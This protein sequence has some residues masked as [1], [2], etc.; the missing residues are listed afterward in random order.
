MDSLERYDL[1]T[2]VVTTV[3]DGPIRDET[4][5]RD[6]GIQDSL[7]SAIAETLDGSFPGVADAG[8]GQES[9]YASTR[10]STS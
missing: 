6:P 5:P 8:R 10:G 3:F 9:G 7:T 2:G 1:R 4:D